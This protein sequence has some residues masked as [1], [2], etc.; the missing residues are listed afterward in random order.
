MRRWSIQDQLE[1]EKKA[2]LESSSME[3]AEK[4]KV[5]KELELREKELN[6]TKEEKKKLAEKLQMLQGKL[7][8]GGVDL[9]EKAK[10]QQHLLDQSAKDLD[11][12]TKKQAQLRKDLEDKENEAL[13]LEE[14]YVN[15][16][17]E[18][19]GKSKKLAKINQMYKSAKA[20]IADMH[21]EHQRRVESLLENI[22]QLNKEM[23]L[24]ELLIE[25]TIPPEFQDL[26]EKHILWNEEIGEWQLHY[27][28]YT[29]NNM[30]QR[31]PTPPP[32]A[33]EQFDKELEMVYWTYGTVAPKE[34][35]TKKEK[36][37]KKE[38]KKKSKKD[39][40][41]TVDLTK[42]PTFFPPSRPK[43]AMQKPF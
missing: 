27:V 32:Q 15:L 36:K 39:V 35:K 2:L 7:I 37:A 23:Q 26:I 14:H 33:F 6:K 24:Q 42:D 10:E 9:L 17:E 22:R 38:K 34:K 21:A 4:E 28:A 18:A 25:H 40:Q 30:R 8:V 16:Q 41:S 11:A 5:A 43:T 20:E 19:V 12:Q 1:K 31:T 13:N 3:A 29:G